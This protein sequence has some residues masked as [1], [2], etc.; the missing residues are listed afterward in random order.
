VRLN[1]L[2]LDRILVTADPDRQVRA[3][4]SLATERT[5][6][7]VPV[8]RAEDAPHF[9]VHEGDVVLVATPVPS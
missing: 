2:D 4:E 3:S 1:V 8:G 9:S 7:H 6:R 5:G